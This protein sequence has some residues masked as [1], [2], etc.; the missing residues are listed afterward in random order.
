MRFTLLI[1]F[2]VLGYFFDEKEGCMGFQTSFI[3]I[4]PS[5]SNWCMAKSKMVCLP[6]VLPGNKYITSGSIGKCISTIYLPLDRY[7]LPMTTCRSIYYI[8]CQIWNVSVC[9]TTFNFCLECS[10][11]H[12]RKTQMCLNNCPHEPK[13]QKHFNYE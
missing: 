7:L 11:N 2:V 4:E 12:L 10:A 6:E 8:H 3:F 5:L 13:F 9:H 1:V